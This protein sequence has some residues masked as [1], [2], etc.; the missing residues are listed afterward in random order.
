MGS[1]Q[2]PGNLLRAG[3]IREDVLRFVIWYSYNEVRRFLGRH[4]GVWPEALR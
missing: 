4:T 3:L 1:K 2:R